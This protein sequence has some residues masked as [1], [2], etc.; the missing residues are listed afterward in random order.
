MTHENTFLFIF[1]FNRIRQYRPACDFDADG[2]LPPLPTAGPAQL[3]IKSAE[4]KFFIY[5]EI[6]LIRLSPME[7]TESVGRLSLIWWTNP[8][9]QIGLR[10]KA[11]LRP[12]TTDV[13]VLKI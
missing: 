2:S 5:T 9:H 13:R 4:V 10:T 6:G 7:A 12:C 1:N 3:N 11:Q 8:A